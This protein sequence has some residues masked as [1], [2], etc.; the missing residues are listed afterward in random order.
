MTFPSNF[1][2]QAASRGSSLFPVSSPGDGPAALT[3]ATT[4]RHQAGVEPAGQAGG[5]KLHKGHGT[6]GLPGG[7]VWAPGGTGVGSQGC[8]GGRK[9]VT[10]E[11]TQ[12]MP[13]A[14]PQTGERSP[15]ARGGA[16]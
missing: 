14:A 2:G 4:S 16:M 8:R 11:G 6:G 12:K 7:R 3:L 5:S 10:L 1:P 15:W 9:P 13:P